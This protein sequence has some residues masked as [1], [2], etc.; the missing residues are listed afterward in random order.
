MSEANEIL[1][2]IVADREAFTADHGQIISGG[3][4]GEWF[5]AEM[6]EIADMELNTELG[7]DARESITL[8]VANRTEA[9][10]IGLHDRVRFTLRGQ[11]CTLQI[12]R[13]TDNPLSPQVHF[14]C[15]KIASG[16]DT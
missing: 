16:K 1:A 6:E 14:G 13:R 8:H 5:T 10:R 3:H 12:L 9:A 4:A 15:M 7:R 2:Y 11:S